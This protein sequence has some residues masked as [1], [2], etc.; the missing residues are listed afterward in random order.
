MVDLSIF[1]DFVILP[2]RFQNDHHF[3]AI[4]YP[5]LTMLIFT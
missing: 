1:F 3:A 4:C 2:P 5:L